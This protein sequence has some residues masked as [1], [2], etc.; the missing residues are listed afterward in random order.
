M[1]HQH[2]LCPVDKAA[3]Y[4]YWRWKK[5]DPGDISHL[6][7]RWRQAGWDPQ[8]WG[9]KKESGSSGIGGLHRIIFILTVLCGVTREGLVDGNAEELIHHTVYEIRW[10][11]QTSAWKRHRYFLHLE[12]FSFQIP[13]GNDYGTLSSSRSPSASPVV[14]IIMPFQRTGCPIIT[15]CE[16]DPNHWV[17]IVLSLPN[18]H[19]RCGLVHHLF[20]KQRL[21]D[22]WC[23]ETNREI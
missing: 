7:S 5:P 6:Q 16:G 18:D 11:G 10:T 19:P 14:D 12:R 21:H 8:N 13:S 22:T 17:I 20:H 1:K 15:I 4:Q 9:G 3:C 23:M 2:P